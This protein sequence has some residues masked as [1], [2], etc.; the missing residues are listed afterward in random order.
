MIFLCYVH[1]HF[2]GATVK[3][4]FPKDKFLQSFP[5]I[6][7]DFWS[8]DSL[9][10]TNVFSAIHVSQKHVSGNVYPKFTYLFPCTCIYMSSISGHILL[11]LKTGPSKV[12]V[13]DRN[14]E[15]EYF[16]H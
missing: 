13:V 15:E 14:Y 10:S 6:I 11:W 8:Q 3:S 9:S 16:V 2:P 12:G 7:G 5:Y 1:L 4:Q